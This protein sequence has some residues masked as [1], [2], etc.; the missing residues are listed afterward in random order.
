MDEDLK[1]IQNDDGSRSFTLTLT[2]DQLNSDQFL[3]NM[4]D[5]GDLLK[6]WE[7]QKSMIGRNNIP[8]AEATEEEW[9][10]VYE[11]ARPA[12]GKYGLDNE[13]LEKF[14]NE[15]GLNKHQAAKLATYVKDLTAVPA[16][17][18][19]QEA[20]ATKL[21]AA[22]G[23]KMAEK[24]TLINAVMKES[25]SE[26]EDNAF[27]ELPNS[28]KV[29]FA[30]LLDKALEKYAVKGA[31]FKVGT[32]GIAPTVGKAD[33]AGYE[34][35]RLEIAKA[36]K[37]LTDIEDRKLREKYGIKYIDVKAGLGF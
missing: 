27:N 36:G 25:W 8:N 33:R 20:L 10:K 31:D 19:S 34:A 28:Q 17:E 5:G 16:E 1:Y 3:N 18:T 11:K 37:N 7:S 12:D 24:V 14:A 30:T 13:N 22:F 15:N 35:E 23:E 32:G 2:Q 6:S 21:T 4:K 26:E 9:A 29:L